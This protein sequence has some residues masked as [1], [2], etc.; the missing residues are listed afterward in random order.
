MA[1]GVLGFWV[2][3]WPL[4]FW[5]L[6]WPL[7]FQVPGFSSSGMAPSSVVPSAGVVGQDMESKGGSTFGD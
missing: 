4:C 2:L 5:I 3:A 1:S 6:V 7:G